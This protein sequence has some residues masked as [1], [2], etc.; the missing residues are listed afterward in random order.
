MKIEPVVIIDSREQTPWTF[1]NLPTER[2]ALD[3]GD[4]SIRGLEHLIAAERKSLPDLLSCIGTHRDRFRRELHRIR[5]YRFRFLVV[6]ADYADLERGGW[7]S[8]IQPAHVLGSL[9]AWTAQY[10][11][12]ITLAGDHEAA[13]RFGERYLFQA[14]RCVA[15][16]NAALGTAEQCV[17]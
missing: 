5:A 8:K 6:E 3:T 7:R 12:P 16:E 4:Y 10:S 1:H 11:L 2:A 17:A 13:A 15:E 9:A 14:A